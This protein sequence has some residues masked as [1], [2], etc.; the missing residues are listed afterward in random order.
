MLPSLDLGFITLQLYPFFWGL[1]WAIGSWYIHQ[2]IPEN[3]K[4]KNI[5]Y[6]ISLFLIAVLGAKYIFDLSGGSFTFSSGLGFV[7][8][9]GLLSAGLYLYILQTLN[10]AWVKVALKP[11]IIILPLCHAI[12]RLGCYCAG[13]CFGLNH[14]PLPLVEAFFLMVIFMIQ[15]KSKNK[16]IM[17]L[18][19]QY[20]ICY[21]VV[22]LALEIFRGDQRGE[23]FGFPPSVWI[24]LALIYLGFFIFSGSRSRRM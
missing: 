6:L 14:F 8:Y 16:P 12:G 5:F 15:L 23:W 19:A 3:F 24:S 20:F 1:A 13:C 2:N 10:I 4:I 7:F 21:G 17:Y 11:M 9:G 18:V 22:R